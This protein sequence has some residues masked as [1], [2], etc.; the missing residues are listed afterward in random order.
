MGS[1]QSKQDQSSKV[2]LPKTPTEFS[3]N[4]VS[5]LDGTIEVSMTDNRLKS[6]TAY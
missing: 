3:N 6:Y 4:L 1:V 2:F 5:K